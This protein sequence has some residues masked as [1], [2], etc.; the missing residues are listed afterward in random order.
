MTLNYGIT[1]QVLRKQYKAR[2]IFLVALPNAL[3]G[4]TSQRRTSEVPL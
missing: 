3:V 2:E 4:R 1:Q